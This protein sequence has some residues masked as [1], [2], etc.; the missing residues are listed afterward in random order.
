MDLFSKYYD[1]FVG[2][3][4]DLISKFIDKAVKQYKNDSQLICDLGCGTACIISR[5]AKLGYDM[6]GIDESENMLMQAR[7]KLSSLGLDS[8]LLLNQNITNFELYGTVDVI[9]ST[10]DTL[11]YILYKKELRGLFYLVKNYL[12]YGG[13]FIFDIN[14]EYKFK[15][16]LADGKFIYDFDDIFCCWQSDYEQKSGK[17]FHELTYFERNKDG[18]FER[19]DSFQEQR[20]YSNEYIQN[21]AKEYSFEIL[22][23]CDNY[24]SKVVTEYTERITYVMKINKQNFK[25]TIDFD[26]LLQ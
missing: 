23:I 24:T 22:Q 19:F 16:T 18:N 21:I 4:Y 25:K 26:M 12:N 11:N 10:L 1:K 7:E 17:C 14:S 8:V 3:D 2:A 5:L 20:F 9:Y 15:S 6:I 13:L